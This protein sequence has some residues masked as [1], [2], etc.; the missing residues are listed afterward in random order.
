[1]KL[2]PNSLN[3]IEIFDKCIKYWKEKQIDM[4]LEESS[5][6]MKE[7]NE[8]NILIMKFKRRMEDT[9]AEQ[10]RTLLIREYETGNDYSIIQRIINELA[11]YSIM[12]S[13]FFPEFEEKLFSMKKFKLQRL[14]DKITQYELNNG[15]KNE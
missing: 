7:M 5:E 3:Q 8:L 2:I 6:L 11:D 9:T 1:M 12:L 4:I 10:L 13:Q 15:V 14:S